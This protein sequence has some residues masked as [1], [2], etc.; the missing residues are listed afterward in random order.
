MP[1]FLDAC[2]EGSVSEEERGERGRAKQDQ[3]MQQLH[4]LERHDPIREH[5]TVAQTLIES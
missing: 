1:V 4:R 5:G 2:E 3:A